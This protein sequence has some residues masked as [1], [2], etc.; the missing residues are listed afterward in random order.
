MYENGHIVVTASSQKKSD[1]SVTR[2][3]KR[4]NTTTPLPPSGA[5]LRFWGAWPKHSRKQSKGECW[6]R[7][8]KQGLD[9]A[10]DEIV[11]HVE[12]LK[13]SQDWSKDAGRFVPAP[14]VYLN[15]RRWEGA[16][17]P[18]DGEG[19]SVSPLYRREGVM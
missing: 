2:E 7:W 5:F 14:L 9:S 1:K 16:E 18:P 15:Q 10:V 8:R 19:E 12:A 4:R 11:A 6:G 17:P 13:R 3:E